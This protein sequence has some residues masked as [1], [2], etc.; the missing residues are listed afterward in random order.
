ML[1]NICLKALFY[2]IFNYVKN[3]F[4]KENLFANSHDMETKKSDIIDNVVF[5]KL[6]AGAQLNRFMVL[7]AQTIT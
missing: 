7:R 3:A 1:N 6:Y 5:V 4:Y 2:H